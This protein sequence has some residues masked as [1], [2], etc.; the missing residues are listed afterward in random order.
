MDMKSFKESLKESKVLWGI[1]KYASEDAHSKGETFEETEFEGNVM[2][3]E[4]INELWTLVCSATGTEYDNSNAYLGV[5][6]GTTGATATDTGLEANGVFVGMDVT[7][8]TFGTS[9][10]ATWKATFGAA[11]A[12]QA[13]AEFCVANGD[14]NGTTLLNHKISAQGTKVVDQ[15]WEL[16]LEITL[17]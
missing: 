11:V 6:T 15:V 13:W 8:P 2:V 3:N 16:T 14:S 10:K 7:Y 12:N 4:G 1:K 5:G 9:Q 17:S